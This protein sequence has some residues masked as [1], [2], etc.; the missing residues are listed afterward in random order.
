MEST[1]LTITFEPTGDEELDA[2]MICVAG[3]TRLRELRQRAR[4]VDYL[5][6]RFGS[7]IEVVTEPDD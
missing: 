1:P 3:L 6:A 5:T 2:I 4:V 7:R